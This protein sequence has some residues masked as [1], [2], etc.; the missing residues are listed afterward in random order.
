[1][2]AQ[3]LARTLRLFETN[4][5]LFR[6]TISEAWDASPDRLWEG[7]A[8]LLASP[9]VVG[10]ESAGFRYLLSF[11][12]QNGNLLGRLVDPDQFTREQAIAIARRVLQLDPTLDVQLALQLNNAPAIPERMAMRAVDVLDAVS[13]PANLLPMLGPL[14]RYEDDRVRS[15]VALM[16]GKGNRNPAWACQRLHESDF[17]VRANAVESI[18][19]VET[20]DAAALFLQ[21]AQDEVPRVAVNG[22]VGLYLCGRT[23]ALELLFGFAGCGSEHFRNSAAWAMGKLR[24]P[25]FQTVLM[26]LARDASSQVRSNAMQAL[27][28]IRSY[29]GAAEAHGC[30]TVKIAEVAT[31]AAVRRMDAFVRTCAEMERLA[32]GPLNFVV[33]EFGRPVVRYTVTELLH[34]DR[35]VIGFALPAP[36]ELEQP[37][38]AKLEAAFR[39]FVAAKPPMQPWGVAVFEN[40][41]KL[42]RGH[43]VGFAIKGEPLLIGLRGCH[44]KPHPGLLP[45]LREL[46]GRSSGEKKLIV[47]GSSMP[48]STSVV[49][50]RRSQAE[51]FLAEA[52]R[53][54]VKIHAIAPPGCTEAHRRMLADLAEGTGG[55]F[56]RS[57]DGEQLVREFESA[58][59]SI[60]PNYRIE[61]EI[62]GERLPPGPVTLQVHSPSGLAEDRAVACYADASTPEGKPR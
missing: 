9:G 3:S 7:V 32:L 41:G 33:E 35:T 10:K 8:A 40:Q 26:K 16:M 50:Y 4:P 56:R 60:Q 19:G 61:Y 28:R 29:C 48:E 17:R 15:K 54:A 27:R 36:G 23:E 18:W 57:E 46:A 14:L 55:R 43:P 20:D 58:V 62:E 59:Y 30:L 37:V 45:G 47:V 31:E 5:V 12:L 51:G 13:D 52:A 44:E 6:K 42:P 25:R 11:L 49:L 1:M 21:A 38:H 39:K 22:A 2:I 34:A 53:A 24:D